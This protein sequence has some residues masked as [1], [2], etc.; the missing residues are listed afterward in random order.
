MKANIYIMLWSS[1]TFESITWPWLSIIGLSNIAITCSRSVI[2]VSGEKTLN[3]KEDFLSTVPW[4]WISVL[5]WETCLH[6]KNSFRGWNLLN[7]KKKVNFWPKWLMD[8][9]VYKNT[10]S[11]CVWDKNQPK[12]RPRAPYTV[13][14][15]AIVKDDA[16]CSLARH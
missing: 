1:G 16:F 5:I 4:N 3:F 13:N 7:L 15:V 2:S 8:C 12:P 9:S 11:C 6:F 14:L 10:Y